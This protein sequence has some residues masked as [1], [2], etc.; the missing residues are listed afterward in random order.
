MR[1][2]ISYRRDDSAGITGRIFDRLVARYGTDSVF[3]DVDNIPIGIDFREHINSILAQTDIT[4]VVVGKRW[5]GPLPRRRRRIDDP[6]D[7]V[8][9]EVE[10]ALRNGMPVVP[11]LVEGGAMPNADQLPDSLKELVYRNGLQ[12]DS[13]RDFDQHIERL[14]RSM[15]PILAQRSNALAEDPQRVE[16]E[17][18]RA[19]A[20]G[21]AEEEKQRAE[22]PKAAPETS[23]V[24]SPG[25]PIPNTISTSTELGGKNISPTTWKAE[26]ERIS[27]L[28]WAILISNQ[29]ELHRLEASLSSGGLLL[30]GQKIAAIQIAFSH[31]YTFTIGR[32][33]FTFAGTA[34]LFSIHTIELRAN[35]DLILSWSKDGK[36]R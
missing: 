32:T 14:I 8:R 1:I 21:Q 30:D 4:L 20:A 19:Q 16:G 34:G 18:Q 35:G 22:A 29:Q 11:I 2:A 15:E 24:A 13:G 27:S 26:F 9:V 7:P 36:A 12:V 17:R 25:S 33:L 28:G 3:R 23:P 31:K 6:A 10:T 5:F